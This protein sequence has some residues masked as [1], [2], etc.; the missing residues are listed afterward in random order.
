M[1]HEMYSE[2]IVMRRM[3]QVSPLILM[4]VGMI[5]ASEWQVVELV[6]SYMGA[7]VLF[8]AVMVGI[9]WLAAE[10]IATLFSRVRYF[11]KVDPRTYVA[12]FRYNMI[13]NMK[14]SLLFLLVYTATFILLF[15]SK[16]SFSF[17]ELFDVERVVGSLLLYSIT[18]LM[19]AIVLGFYLYVKLT[20]FNPTPPKRKE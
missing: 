1:M 18:I 7:Y 16:Y 2:S 11:R 3:I 8:T 9:L 14:T 6:L 12:I 10:G 15:F 5:V 19:Y 13:E 17:T 4:I 20:F